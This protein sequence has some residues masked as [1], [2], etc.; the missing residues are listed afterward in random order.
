MKLDVVYFPPC[1][2]LLLIQNSHWVANS[3]REKR[4]ALRHIP[5][6]TLPT[7]NPMEAGR[8]QVI[9]IVKDVSVDS[10]SESL[11]VNPALASL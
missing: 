9:I 11:G 2:Y 7:S 8:E 1:S 3:F 4:K 6:A 10:G 5:R